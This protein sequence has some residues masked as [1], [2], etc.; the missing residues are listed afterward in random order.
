MDEHEEA[1]RQ[2]ARRLR[3]ADTARDKARDEHVDAVLAAL[4]AGRPP[5]AIVDLS[6]FT[7]THLRKLA[8][9]NGIPPASKR[10]RAPGI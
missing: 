2:T 6:P 4:R 8:R 10:R 1:V 5:T 3:A 7:A 9:D